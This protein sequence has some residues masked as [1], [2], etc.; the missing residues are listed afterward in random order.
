MK[1]KLKNK[2]KAFKLM[3]GYYALNVAVFLVLMYFRFDIRSMGDLLYAVAKNCAIMTI[4][5]V[6]VACTSGFFTCSDEKSTVKSLHILSGV[7]LV[8][9][10]ILHTVSHF[11]RMVNDVGLIR[12]VTVYSGCLILLYLI[13]F[14]ILSIRKIRKRNFNVFFY[15]HTILIINVCII[16]ILHSFYF[17]VFPTLLMVAHYGKRFVMRCL[18]VKQ[19]RVDA[20]DGF[21]KLSLVYEN[22]FLFRYLI[23]NQLAENGCSDAWLVCYNMSRFQRHPFTVCDWYDTDTGKTVLVFALNANGDWKSLLCKIVHQNINLN[24]YNFGLS[25][26]VDTVGKSSVTAALEHCRVLFLARDIMITSAISYLMCLHRIAKMRTHHRHVDIYFEVSK[27]D[28]VHLLMTHLKEM[29]NVSYVRVN[30]N[31]I[32]GDSE[33]CNRIDNALRENYCDAVQTYRIHSNEKKCLSDIVDSFDGGR[34]HLH[35]NSSQLLRKMK[36][37]LKEIELGKN[38]TSFTCLHF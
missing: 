26:A 8:L 20:F 32:C 12:P 37:T 35:C 27:I 36:R 4:I 10:S 30:L 34:I 16:G 31:I 6:Q 15:S 11:I 1:F 18:K 13:L 24:L 21:H 22:T 28:Y 14:M 29:C 19:V 33:K 17:L 7:T 3:C 2:S 38:S 5:N 9:F 23:R 25:M